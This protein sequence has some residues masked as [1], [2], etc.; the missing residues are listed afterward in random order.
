MRQFV[1]NLIAILGIVLLTGGCAINRPKPVTI[2]PTYSFVRSTAAPANPTAGAPVAIAR[3]NA[4][5]ARQKSR[6]E[7]Q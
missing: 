1:V 2:D 6:S 7:S 5:R 4:Q 3:F